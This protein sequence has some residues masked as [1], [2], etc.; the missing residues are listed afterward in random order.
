MNFVA[1]FIRF[2]A[3]QKFWISVMIWQSYREFKGA[4]FF[5]TQCIYRLTGGCAKSVMCS[6]NATE[7]LY[8]ERK[9]C[10]LD[11][12]RWR[13]RLV[14][15][16]D[17]SPSL[18]IVLASSSC[19]AADAAARAKWPNKLRKSRTVLSPFAETWRQT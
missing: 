5:E 17:R 6:E 13:L 7:K 19:R 14:T 15:R 2:P 4:N 10:I 16:S 1:N 8:V 18:I 3:I 12:I 11:S 9:S